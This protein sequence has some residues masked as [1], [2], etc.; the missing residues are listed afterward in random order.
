M[1]IL[2]DGVNAV[3]TGRNMAMVTF[4][5][6][7]NAVLRVYPEA[8]IDIQLVREGDDFKVAKKS[9]AVMYSHNIADPF[10]D[11]EAKIIGAYAVFKTKRGEFLETLNKTDYEK[12]EK[13][14]KMSYLWDQWPSEFWLK[15]VIKR[16]CKRH[17]Y[18]IVAEIDKVDNDDFGLEEKV[19]ASED[20][21]SE[22]I[23]AVKN[24]QKASGAAK[25]P[26]VASVARKSSDSE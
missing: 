24:D 8:Q 11:Q 19:K 17:F 23:E 5:G 16:A 13:S 20:K 4:H 18:D 12:M 3:I 2:I 26:R 22:I 6:Y 1:G 15:S 14:S 21:K 9:G 10:A 7:K 25:Q